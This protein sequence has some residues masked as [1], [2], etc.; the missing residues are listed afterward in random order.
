MKN[1]TFLYKICLLFVAV[2]LLALH[3]ARLLAQSYL[4]PVSGAASY[5]TCTGTV[6]D[7]G[8]PT[9]PHDVNA[10]GT[11]TLRPGTAGAKLKLEFS[12]LEVDSVNTGLYV[13]DGPDTKSPIIGRFYT[14]KPTVYA[15]GSTGALTIAM[16]AYGYPLRGFAATISCYTGTPPVPDLAITTLSVVPALALAGD[17]V[18]TRTRVGNLAGGLANYRVRYLLSTNTTLDANDTEL[19]ASDYTM[20]AGSAFS[21]FQDLTLPAST[22]PGKYYMLVVAQ[23]VGATETN[24]ANN[25]AYAPLTVPPPTALPDLAIT[26]L[27]YNGKISEGSVLEIIVRQQNF[28]ATLAQSA[29]LGYYLSTDAVL[30]D[31]DQLL[32]QAPGAVPFIGKSSIMY[33]TVALPPAMAPGPYYLLGVADYLDQVIEADEQ[34]N[35]YA[36]PITLLPPSVD[37]SFGKRVSAEPSQVGPGDNLTISYFLQNEG[38]TP[39][40][41]A[42]VGYY[43]S[44][45]RNLS[46]DD[47]LLDHSAAGPLLPGLFTG[48]TVTRRLP[49]PAA[50]PLGKRYLLLVAD[51]RREIAETNET[52]NV[53]TLLLDVVVPQVDLVP[54]AVRN[55]SVYEPAV[56]SY[57]NTRCTLANQ[58]STVAYPAT[59]AY[60]YSTDDRLSPDDVLLGQ[61]AL[62]PLASGASQE[63]YHAVMLPATAAIGTAYV[64]Y[65]ADHLAQVA[66]TNEANNVVALPIKVGALSV[67]LV[68]DNKFEVLPT[69]AAPGTEVK[70]SYSFNNLGSVPVNNPSVGFYL[71]V[72]DTWSTDD[73]Y[74]GSSRAYTLYPR[75]AFSKTSSFLL[76]P[77]TAPGIYFVLGVADDLNEFAETNE[78]NNVRATQ[79]E[80]TRARPDLAVLANPFPFLAPRLAL[81][82]GQVSTECYVNNLGAG[83]AAASTMAYYL[84]TDP[85]LSPNDILLSSTPTARL[86]PGYSTLV[87]GSF[88]VPIA[89]PTGRYYVLFVADYLKQLNDLDQ[90]NNVSTNTLSVT[91]STL[92]L[93]TREQLAGY[94]L[95]VWPVP[96]AGSAPVQVQLSGL[97]ARA[98]ATLTLYNS[99]G[100][101]VA[102][103]PLAL[104]P[105]RP[106][107]A[108]LPTT[109]L[110]AGVYVLSITGPDLHATRRLVID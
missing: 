101:A 14:G 8:G 87:A 51:Y 52:N 80:V 23:L 100:Q 88:T 63:I 4:M 67:D 30:S 49:L 42:T 21:L 33:H 44:A 15:T 81:A 46:A 38:N 103:R 89:T 41:S 66:E 1:F 83:P 26:T 29:A 37:V 84:S 105:G 90:R 102:T 75:S 79:L 55:G 73:V 92:P 50:T 20:P 61:D 27:A 6:Y 95:A 74:I 22:A 69:Q 77:A 56:G 68:L 32:G 86:Q 93:A 17:Y 39:L 35:T 57:F 62:A 96:V 82:G 34:N 28:G 109:G 16:V 45:D 70:V 19:T 97:G 91:G 31:D 85:V 65:V 13:Y 106:N 72:D 53:A 24:T 59:V 5:T 71:S 99:L 25:V 110:A 9:D 47:V 36:L 78:A 107:R 11:L 76:S 58:G 94:E 7:D 64:L 18:T 40:D 10:S 48:R 54:T 98:E 2:G 104:V 12:M 108:E 43:L 3:P 60:Y